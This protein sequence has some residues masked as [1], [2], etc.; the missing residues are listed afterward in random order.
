MAPLSEILSFSKKR[1]S[2]L[3][4]KLES[5]LSQGDVKSVHD[6]RVTSRRLNEPIQ[7]FEKWVGRGQTRQARK[8]LRKVRRQFEDVRDLD[9][10]QI[11]LSQPR[12]APDMNAHDLA[13][14]EGLLTTRRQRA[15][16][17][18]R[19]R[20][21]DLDCESVIETVEKSFEAI[22]DELGDSDPADVHD[23]LLHQC[24]TRACDLL[25]GA[26]PDRPDVD[27]HQ[28]RIRLKRLRYS[29]ELLY[30][31]EEREND[32]LLRALT[33]MQ[34]L[35]GG[36]NDSLVAVE[37][38]S[39]LARKEA[40]V[41]AQP[42]WSA[43]LFE[44]AARRARLADEDRH[45]IISSWPAVRTR[46]LAVFEMPVSDSSSDVRQTTSS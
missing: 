39:R 23:R 33:G 32:E 20:C 19:R 3:S 11:S 27:L 12:T 1:L 18:A 21:R 26:P 17:Q 36:W 41:A 7:L 43:A 6:L 16:D 14:F 38:I 9:V 5:A 29:T 42:A 45:A 28:T 30:R 15:L 37:W 4:G 24:R 8:H 46:I 31:L 22:E 44:Y 2:R 13:Q 25:D 35:L 10:L 34:D 40:F